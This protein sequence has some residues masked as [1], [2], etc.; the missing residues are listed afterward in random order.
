VYAQ[1]LTRSSRPAFLDDLEVCGLGC[2]VEDVQ[3]MDDRLAGPWT[4]P[5]SNIQAARMGC[6]SRTFI[7]GDAG[8]G[9]DVLLAGGRVLLAAAELTFPAHP[10]NPQHKVC[11][12]SL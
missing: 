1:A 5:S 11:K 12:S 8:A 10:A 4:S 3:S 7:T 9:G 2:G 6:G